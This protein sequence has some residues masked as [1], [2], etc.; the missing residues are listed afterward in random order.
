MV[1]WPITL[2]ELVTEWNDRE[3]RLSFLLAAV[4]SP[5]TWWPETVHIY[6]VK[7]SEGHKSEGRQKPRCQQGHALLEA[8]GERIHFL[9]FPASR[10]SF[11]GL[12]LLPPSS[13][14]GV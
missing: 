2:R 9:A 5:Q 3:I 7:S 11:R 6:S 14:P 12:G 1:T 10:A 13:K 8:L 4:T